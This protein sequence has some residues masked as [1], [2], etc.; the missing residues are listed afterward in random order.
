[1]N[2]I[3]QIYERILEVLGLFSEN[4]LISYQRRTP[5]MS[6]L[7]VI[8]LNIT[9]EYLSIDSELQLFRKLPNSL[10][11]KIERSVY[12]KRKRR[13]SL[14]TEQIR[15]RI[16]M[17]FNEFEDI[18]IVDSMPMKVC[19]NARSTRSKICKEQSY[20]SPTY[21]YCASQKL[22]FYGYKLHAVC[23]LNG[24]IKNF[25]ISP[26]SVHDIHYLKDSGEQMRNCTLIGDRGYLSAKVQIDLFNYAN[27]KLDTPMRSNQKDY[28]PQFSLYKKKRKRIETFFSQLCDQFM[29]KRNNAKTFEGF[30]TRIISKITAATVI[31]YINK[32]IFQRKLNHLKIS[33]I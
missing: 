12:N 1:M 25:D 30:K 11:N 22:Y 28:I 9:A 29:I 33:I 31:Q 2:N 13:L 8:S 32:F 6:D 18:F 5:K 24:V 21:G 27:I 15:Q 7:E 23:S 19:E 17:E 16:S 4:Q 20:S 26:A 3:E 10:I 14:Q